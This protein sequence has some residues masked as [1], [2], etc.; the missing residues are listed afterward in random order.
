VEVD[1]KRFFD[2][3]DHELLM[4]RVASEIADSKLLRLL[5]G[6]L[7]SGVMEEG[8]VRS[9]VAGTPQ[10]GVISPLLA[11]IYLH[12]FDRKMTGRGYQVVRYADDFVIMCK[13]ERKAKRALEVCREVLTKDLRLELNAEKTRVV[14]FREGFDFLGF[15]LQSRFKKP[16]AKSVE[17][18]KDKVRHLTRRQHPEKVDQVIEALNPVIRGWGNYYRKGNWKVMAG[19]LDAW[20]RMRL[21]SFIQ[22]HAIVRSKYNAIYSN[23]YFQKKGLVKLTGLVNPTPC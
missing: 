5:R 3:L 23:A 7:V 13:L 17:S 16:R 6:W 20:I 11:N 18:F 19:E 1:L 9:Q 10:G 14:S 2:T 22:K 15:R 8:E 12:A 4:D 21:R